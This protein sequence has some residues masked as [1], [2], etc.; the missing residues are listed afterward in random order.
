MGKE[1]EPARQSVSKVFES[2]A[3]CGI[4]EGNFRGGMDVKRKLWTTLLLGVLC[5]GVVRMVYSE[6]GSSDDPLV[7]RSF[8][9][10]KIAE[11]RSYIDSKLSSS[12][13]TGGVNQVTSALPVPATGED[14][15]KVVEVP[16]NGFLICKG[17][18]EII[19]RSGLARAIAVV[20]GTTVNGLSDLTVGYDLGMDDDLVP[21]HH[22]IVPRDDGRGAKCVTKCFFLVKGPYEVR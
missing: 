3:E 4:M 13:T 5:L 19:L 1:I 21:N 17:G 2:A 11:L 12:T 22:I 10:S 16:A 8:V 20:S 18:T 15:W 6:A 14:I 9:E 7:S